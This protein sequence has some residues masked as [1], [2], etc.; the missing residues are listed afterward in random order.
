VI[1]CFNGELYTLCAGGLR[2]IIEGICND[3]K[4]KDGP[5]D[6]KLKD[7]TSKTVRKKTV[8]GK[9][10]GL[11]EKGILTR[12]NADIL[13]EHRFLSNEALH[14]LTQPSKDE[15]TLA[16]QIIEH[17]F[18]NIYELPNKVDD[19]RARIAKRKQHKTR[20]RGTAIKRTIF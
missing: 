18:E 13:H 7:G 2:A 1:D 4:I 15:L 10:S 20:K 5:V 16:I 19:L 3:R 6:I 9:I 11:F 14:E 12:Q 8:E 17:I